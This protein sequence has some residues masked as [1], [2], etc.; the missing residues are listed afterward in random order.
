MRLTCPHCSTEYEVPDAA[1]AGRRWLRCDRCGH[2][3]RQEEPDAAPP[4]VVPE[5]EPVPEILVTPEVSKPAHVTSENLPKFLTR[6]DP[7][8]DQAEGDEQGLTERRRGIGIESQPRRPIRKKR[9]PRG[10]I[11]VLVALIIIAAAF[12]IYR[13]F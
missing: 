6:R 2:Q 1:L 9:A 7:R 13:S 11:L 12:F 8:G 3:W 10:R 4:D 5:P